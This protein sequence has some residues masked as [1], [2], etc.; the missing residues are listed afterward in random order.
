MGLPRNLQDSLNTHLE[1]KDKFQFLLIGFAAGTHVVQSIREAFH[2][3]KDRGV[4]ES[5]RGRDIVQWWCRQIQRP[6]SSSQDELTPQKAELYVGLLRRGVHDEPAFRTVEVPLYF[7]PRLKQMNSELEQRDRDAIELR[8]KIR[9]IRDRVYASRTFPLALKAIIFERD[10]YT[11]R[12]CLRDRVALQKAGLYLECDHILAWEDGG[13]T[14][15]DNGQTV[16]CDCNKAKHHAKH[17]LGLITR[18]NKNP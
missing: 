9:L 5:K 2:N 16:C 7:L 18:L 8:E 6:A 14:K 1:E 15:Y 12:I 17:Y 10:N 13:L 4:S 11:C 3:D